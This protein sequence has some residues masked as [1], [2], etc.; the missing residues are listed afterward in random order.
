MMDYSVLR[1]HSQTIPK[2][3]GTS[4][5]L[6]SARSSWVDC[7]SWRP[8]A[9]S[10]MS[11]PAI[12]VSLEKTREGRLQTICS[13]PTCT[14]WSLIY[15]I[16]QGKIMEIHFFSN[17]IGTNLMPG[18]FRLVPGCFRRVP[19]RFRLWFLRFLVNFSKSSCM[20]FFSCRRKMSNYHA[21]YFLVKGKCQIIM[22]VFSSKRKMSNYHAWDF[23]S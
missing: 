9:L 6:S 3:E 23:L 21:W 11:T 1:L 8:S 7:S 22:H 10:T 17:L 13:R 5:F 18:C 14:S 15:G 12:N 4:N 16:I 2:D 20:I 19:G